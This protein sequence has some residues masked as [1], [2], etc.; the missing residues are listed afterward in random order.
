MLVN[1]TVQIKIISSLEQKILVN[2]TVTELIQMSIWMVLEEE[3]ELAFF[4]T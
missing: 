1:L 3:G 2:I 4:C